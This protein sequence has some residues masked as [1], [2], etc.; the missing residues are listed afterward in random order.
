MLLQCL[1]QRM[2]AQRLARLT[3]ER[4]E[5]RSARRAST[6]MTIAKRCVQ[7]IEH[8]A[9]GGGNA[10]IVDEPR[11]TQRR[12][13]LRERGIGQKRAGRLAFGEVCNRLDVEIQR[14]GEQPAGRAVGTDV[15]WI[16]RK[17][18]V[19]RID[20]HDAGATG[21]A[22]R[23]DLAQIGEVADAPVAGTPH[24]VELNRRAPGPS[25]VAKRD[26]TM[27]SGRRDGDVRMRH[28][29][30]PGRER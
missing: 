2:L 17:Q 14:V 11:V 24:A 29:L 22:V 26:G 8:F 25:A 13:A 3:L 28:D 6:A 4:R 30:V 21:P 15:P 7:Q 5:A 18:R 10:G 1:E 19:Q 27:T 23:N 9:F 16:V 20:A 12:E